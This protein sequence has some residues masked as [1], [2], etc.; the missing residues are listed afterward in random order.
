MEASEVRVDVD[1]PYKPRSFEYE[2]QAPL[3]HLLIR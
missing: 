2:D 3:V 1:R